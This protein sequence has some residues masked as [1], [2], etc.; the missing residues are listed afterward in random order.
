MNH[1]FCCGCAEGPCPT[2]NWLSC[3]DPLYVTILSINL[4]RDYVLCDSGAYT[5][6][7][8][9][10]PHEISLTVALDLERL[11]FRREFVTGDPSLGDFYRYTIDPAVSNTGTISFS[12]QTG[13][14]GAGI[15]YDSDGNGTCD[16][17][18]DADAVGSFSFDLFDP[19]T[20]HGVSRC[21]GT[22]TPVLIEGV[23]KYQLVVDIEAY[24]YDGFEFSFLY[25]TGPLSASVGANTSYLSVRVRLTYEAPY[26]A[27][28]CPH[29]L[30]WSAVNGAMYVNTV[31]VFAIPEDAYTLA[32]P[33]GSPYACS[34]VSP[35]A[36]YQEQSMNQ[37]WPMTVLFPPGVGG[38]GGGP[39]IIEDASGFLF[40]TQDTPSLGIATT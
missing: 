22:I 3:A 34:P 13:A 17:N 28:K 31:P 6:C 27:T 20:D 36:C 11:V 23:C 35:S 9:G 37:P 5:A 39:S 15:P 18:F 25:A 16:G 40:Q 8:S 30:S 38:G 19:P 21:S 33:A 26:D 12:V 7:S 24:K 10:Y 14:V 4:E 29:Q 1:R 32:C 2:D